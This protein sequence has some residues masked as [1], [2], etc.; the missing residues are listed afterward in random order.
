MCGLFE[1]VWL[2]GEVLGAVYE[3]VRVGVL[4]HILG[5]VCFRAWWRDRA[6]E[7]IELGVVGLP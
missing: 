1:G 2:F 5:V 7:R 3:S 4:G 6:L